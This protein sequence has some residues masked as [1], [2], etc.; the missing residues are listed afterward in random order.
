M[1]ELFHK[2]FLECLTNSPHLLLIQ[3]KNKIDG[4][5]SVKKIA[6]ETEMDIELVKM[7]F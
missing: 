2:N 4:Y 6:S 7:C 1:D 5:K 3:V